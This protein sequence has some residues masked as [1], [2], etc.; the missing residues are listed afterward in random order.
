LVGRGDL[1][2]EDPLPL[3]TTLQVAGEIVAAK[4]ADTQILKGEHAEVLAALHSLEATTGPVR[5]HLEECLGLIDAN[6]RCRECGRLAAWGMWRDTVHK[7]GPGC[8]STIPG[9]I[10]VRYLRW[11]WR[12]PEG[13]PLLGNVLVRRRLRKRRSDPTANGQHP[14]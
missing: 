13:V 2:T 7:E 6:G 1:V 5:E 12:H 8:F 9:V 4:V 10:Q 3:A 11:A 14:G